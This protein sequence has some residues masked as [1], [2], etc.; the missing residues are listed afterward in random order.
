MRVPFP[1]FTNGTAT[2]DSHWDG[3][4]NYNAMNVKVERRSSNLALLAVYTW[5]KS[6]DDK[7]AAAGIGATNGFAGHMDDHD[8]KLDYARS[9]F[10]V[11]QRFV[12]S[13]V[14]NL[15][16]GRG[17][18][19]LSNINR[20]AN[21]AVGGWEL[22]GIATFQEGFPFSVL[23]N[24][25]YGLLEAF[26]QRSDLVGNP[27]TGFR[28]SINEWFNTSAY[29]QPLAGAFGTSGRNSLLDPGINNWDM[30]LAKN[31]AIGERVN[32]QFRFES[33]NTFNHTQWGVDPNSPAAAASGPGTGAVDR[34]VND[35]APSAN[36]NFGRIVSARP[37]RVLQ[38]GGKLTF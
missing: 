14:W 25:T 17:Q 34:N 36:T 15:P 29:A 19:Y 2:L 21:L 22:T 10:N 4:S 9:D 6:M 13:Y 11:G 23:A 37:G 30:G 38:L 28:K 12:G 3:Y 16:F 5:A 31:F 18:H 27:H 8:P 26:N 20:P 1:N 33:F 7:S 32:F 35:Q 24:D